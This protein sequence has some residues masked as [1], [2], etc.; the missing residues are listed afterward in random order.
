MPLARSRSNRV[1]CTSCGLDVVTAAAT[2]AQSTE[3]RPKAEELDRATNGPC[4]STAVVPARDA[5]E[6]A[7]AAVGEKLLQGWTML[8]ESCRNCGLPLLKDAGGLVVCVGCQRDASGQASG[9]DVGMTTEREGRELMTR[10]G[11]QVVGNGG[12]AVGSALTG[13]AVT[14]DASPVRG[15]EADSEGEGN[16]RVPRVGGGGRRIGIL[17]MA[18][19][20]G[21]GTLPMAGRALD[22]QGDGETDV[23]LREELR[24]TELEIGRA[25]RTV[26]RRMEG[27]RDVEGLKV[28]ATAIQELAKAVLD[29]KDARRL[30]AYED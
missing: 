16:R 7:S 11:V 20:R 3:E 18:G 2:P 29:V 30:A 17:P 12:L 26:R 27:R 23:D 4:S 15:E 25:L 5:S 19:G 8:D 1:I 22:G 14:R 9:S 24:L 13:G 10:G 6:A 21:V 28:M